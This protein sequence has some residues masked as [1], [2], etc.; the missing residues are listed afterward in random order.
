MTDTHSSPNDARRRTRRRLLRATG[1]LGAVLAL[2]G[3]LPATGS[4][5]GTPVTFDAGPDAV[6]LEGGL[7]T[8]T[9]AIAD[10]NDDG[11]PGW[12]Y[13]T[14]YGDG[15][16]TVGTT[17][18]PTIELQHPYGNGPAAYVTTVTVTDVPGELASDTFAV[19]VLNV[20]PTIVITGAASTTPEGTA[21]TF[22]VDATDPGDPRSA[23]SYIVD[24]GEGFSVQVNRPLGQATHTYSDDPDGPVNSITRSINVSVYDDTSG[25][26]ITFPIVVTD[27]APTIALSGAAS[28]PVGAP[29]SLTLAAVTDPA[30]T[31]TVTSRTINWGD[32]TS[33]VVAT[34]GTF[35]HTYATSG[36]RTITVDLVNEDGTHLAAGSL[37]VS[38]TPVVPTAP[39]NLTATA[40]SKS[41]IQLNWT[42][43]STGQTAVYV[44]RCKNAGCT[45]FTRV[46]TL[47]G[48]ATSYRNTGLSSRTTY[49]YRVRAQNTA[50]LSAYSNTAT[51][52]TL[53][54]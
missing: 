52:T 13:T 46:A 27:V 31:D 5:L 10:G 6:V 30:R 45:T 48:S 22:T 32:G 14:E 51:A 54:R 16:V 36:T 19:T 47:T 2:T 26:S 34:G 25:S 24:W 53:R 9:I 1:T 15:V 40:T 28:V 20:A 17:L 23:L 41:V 38:V 11:E 18:T 39:T 33:D 43:T 7:F 3:A 8:R 44:E 21:Y 35:T 29:Y 42:N 37:A 49:T 12:T 4:A 50:G